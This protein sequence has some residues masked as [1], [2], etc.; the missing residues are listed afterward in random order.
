MSAAAVVIAAGVL[1]LGVVQ[2]PA[3]AAPNNVSGTVTES[4]TAGGG[5]AQ[6][7]NVTVYPQAGGPA[8][9]STTTDSSGNYGFDLPD[10][11][12]TVTAQPP[13]N[14]TTDA[15]TSITVTVAGG[16][17]TSG[18]NPP[19]IALEAANLSGTVSESATAGGAAAPN[20]NVQA[21]EQN[22]PNGTSTQTDS[23]GH[24]R[25]FVPDG[26]W[27][28]TA[29]PPNG[30]T[31]DAATS[32]TVTVSGGTIISGPNPPNIILQ[33]VNLSGTVYESDGTTPAANTNVQL[34][35]QN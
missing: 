9:T 24:Y 1:S 18:P 5:A 16:V 15:A 22:S 26:T 33:K 35:E 7:T 8:Q 11:N 21:Q 29:Q 34:Q 20:T 12:W 6:N 32:I 30:D 28:I 2:A 14:D 3:G 31:T 23:S 19:N 25:L 10:G 4:A 17:I 13:S 27:V